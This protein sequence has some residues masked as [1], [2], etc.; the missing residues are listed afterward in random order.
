VYGYT[1]N[2]DGNTDLQETSIPLPTSG[3]GG[4]PPF[5]KLNY[6][7]SKHQSL[8]HFHSILSTTLGASLVIRL[9]DWWRPFLE[10]KPCP[11]KQ[12]KPI[13]LI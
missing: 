7:C 5:Q 13:L 3:C 2:T 1:G 11:S 12:R 8:R 4:D 10:P 9:W 6:L